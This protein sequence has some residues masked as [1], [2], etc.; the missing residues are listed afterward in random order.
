MRSRRGTRM[1]PRTGVSAKEKGAF[2]SYFIGGFECSTHQR[3]DGR[4]LDLVAA[5]GHDRLVFED[6][7]ELAL[8]DVRTVRDGIRWYLVEQTPGAYEWSSFQP[9]LDAAQRAN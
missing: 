6:Y 2:R 4:R 9:M 3:C 1:F 5:T 7:E 8:H